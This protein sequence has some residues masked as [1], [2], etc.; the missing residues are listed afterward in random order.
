MS[1]FE[2][3]DKIFLIREREIVQEYVNMRCTF[4]PYKSEAKED[5]YFLQKEGLFNVGDIIFSSLISGRFLFSSKEELIE[6]L[7]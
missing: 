5:F 3:G 6:S 7:K 4:V 1:K 2:I